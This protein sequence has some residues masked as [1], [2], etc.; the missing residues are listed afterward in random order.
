MWRL[1]AWFL[2]DPRLVRL[3]KQDIHQYFQFNTGSVTSSGVLWA[4][5]KATIRGN[6]KAHI[7]RQEKEKLQLITD[8]KVKILQAEREET[9]PWERQLALD[10]SS[11]VQI[12]LEEAR[13][14]WRA[15]TQRV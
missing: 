6:T 14:C 12:Q 15:S 11:L 1:K 4:A 2:Q 7:R 8:L 9:G 10:R 13:A 3:R 5:G